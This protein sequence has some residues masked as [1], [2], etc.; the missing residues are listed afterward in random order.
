MRSLVSGRTGDRSVWRA[1]A[2]GW[3]VAYIRRVADSISTTWSTTVT[4]RRWHLAADARIKPECP[5]LLVWVKSRYDKGDAS[6]INCPF[7]REE[8]YAFINALVD[9]KCFEVVSDNY[10]TDSDGTGIVHIAPAFGEDDNRVCKQNGIGFV[11][12]VGLDGC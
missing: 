2:T 8:Y 4:R 10:V 9:G 6:Y 12:P 1:Q 3:P 7:N 5:F 11:N